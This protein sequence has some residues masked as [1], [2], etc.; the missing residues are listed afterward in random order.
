MVRAVARPDRAHGHAVSAHQTDFRGSQ[1]PRR[2]ASS[3]SDTLGCRWR[4]VRGGGAP[5]LAV[6]VDASKVGR[7]GRGLQLHRGHPVGA[8]RRG[9]RPL[10]PTTRYAELAQVDAVVI[11]VPTPL[12]ANREPDLQPL[13]SAGSA[14]AGVLQEGSS[15]CWSRR[16]IPGT[17][18]ERLAPLLE[19]SGLRAGDTFNLAFSPER[20]DPGRTDYTIRTTPRSSAASRRRAWSALRALR[21]VCEPSSRFRHRG[22]RAHEAAREHLPLRQHRAGQRDRD[23]LRPHGHRRL[24]GR[25]RGRHEAVRVH[26]LQARARAWAA[27]ASRST[28]SIWPGRRASTTPR[29]SSSSSPARSTP[30]CPGSASRRS[31]GALNDDSRR[32]AAPAWGSSACRTR[33]ASATCASR[34]RSRSCD[35]FAARRAARLPRP[36]RAGAPELGLRSAELPGAR[37]EGADLALIVTAHPLGGPPR[38]HRDRAGHARPARR[39]PPLRRDRPAALIRSGRRGRRGPRRRRRPPARW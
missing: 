21:A 22:R 31:P 24:G 34:P 38:D 27:T 2:S 3:A 26:V 12:T 39:H 33:P 37:A 16:P 14:L 25:R 19:E 10:H 6:D 15:S 28:R 11:A 23:A 8:A 7:S 5:R 35:S 1:R 18:R 32:C 13:I 17:T 9:A 20:I 30:P 29:R 4:S 36:V